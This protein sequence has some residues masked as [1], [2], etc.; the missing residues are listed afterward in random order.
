MTQFAIQTQIETIKQVTEKVLQSKEATR[1][2]LQDA[3]ILQPKPKQSKKE[4]I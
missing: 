2:F 1:K 3:G 4:K